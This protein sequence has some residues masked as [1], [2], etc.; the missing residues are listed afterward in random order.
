MNV[1]WK[2]I[3]PD[4]IVSSEGVV[5]SRKFGKLKALKPAQDSDGYPF[6]QI[7]MGGAKRIRP[8]H[9]LVAEAFLGP[10]PTPAHQVNHKDGVRLNNRDHNLEWMTHGQ[11]QKHRYDVLKH[12]AARGRA[13]GHAKL[14]END[15][16]T[17][18]ARCASGESQRAV[19]ADYGVCQPNVWFIVQRKTWEWVV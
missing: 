1:E 5:L 8:I 11:N 2:E 12:G 6:V 17:I 18:R 3:N 9:Q 16:P 10:R 7:Y 14:T 13:T 19:A 15:I 4:Y